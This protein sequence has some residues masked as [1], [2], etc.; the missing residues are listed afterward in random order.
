MRGIRTYD[1]TRISLKSYSLDHKSL[2]EGIH[3]VFYDKKIKFSEQRS[4][5]TRDF[6]KEITAFQISIRNMAKNSLN[7]WS[8]SIFVPLEH[9]WPINLPKLLG[10]SFPRP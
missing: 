2:Y 7:P 6:E 4:R 1:L 3:E 8:I 9:P 10:F 5:K